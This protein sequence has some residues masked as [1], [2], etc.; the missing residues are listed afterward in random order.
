MQCAS[1]CGGAAAAQASSFAPRR[2]IGFRR[3]RVHGRR[4]Y[5]AEVRS[6]IRSG[7]ILRH[8]RSSCALAE[9]RGPGRGPGLRRRY[10]SRSRDRGV[11]CAEFSVLEP[12]SLTGRTYLLR[13]MGAR[14]GA[15]SWMFGDCD[16][17]QASCVCF[18]SLSCAYPRAHS[19]ASAHTALP[20]LQAIGA[21]QRL[22]CRRHGGRLLWRDAMY[23]VPASG[24]WRRL[25]RGR[26]TRA[27]CDPC[28]RRA[29]AAGGGVRDEERA[30]ERD[31]ASNWSRAAHAGG[32][33]PSWLESPTTGLQV[34]ARAR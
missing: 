12:C 11:G 18:S 8:A 29:A 15:P 10:V 2:Q 21:T 22:G 20:V 5:R 33:A 28:G 4:A 1:R 34:A 30:A 19:H 7:G 23:R 25:R 24:V 16:E 9:C 3:P 26:R 27:R 17:K 32:V 13:A 6:W 14:S 31:S